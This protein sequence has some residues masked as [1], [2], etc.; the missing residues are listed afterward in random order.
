MN[1]GKKGE[2]KAA[3]LL[4]KKGFKVLCRNYICRVGEI[5]LIAQKK[6]LLVFCEVKTRNNTKY[7][8]PF[9]A[10][11][12]YKATMIFTGIRHFKH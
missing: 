1:L 9:E 12:K 2:K 3:F 7:G 10:V 8:Q 5:D 11:N 4:K 6:D